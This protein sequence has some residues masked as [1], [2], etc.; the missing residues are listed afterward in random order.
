MNALI[1]K[2]FTSYLIMPFLAVV[3]TF[4]A[5]LISKKNKLFSNKKT[6]FYVL[7]AGLLLS[8][9]GLLGFLDYE[10]M[11]YYYIGLFILYLLA[12]WGNISWIRKMVPNVANEG[13]PYIMEFLVHFAIM[14]IGAAL[15]SVIF[16]LCNELQY[17]LWACTCV[18]GFV[19]PT[20]F[21]H[22]YQQYMDIPLE[23]HKTWSYSYN[24]DLSGFEYMDYNKLMLIELEFFKEVYDATSTK[25]KVKAPDNLAFGT[26]FQKFILDYNVKFPST[27]IE[28]KDKTKK[29]D[30]KWIFYVKRSFFLPRKYIDYEL[31]IPQNQ[32]KEK[33]T[34]IAKR[35]FQNEDENRNENEKGNESVSESGSGNGNGNENK[36][37]NESNNKPNA[38]KD[39]M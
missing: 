37:E 16:N 18:L 39:I 25:V 22:T 15:F 24:E 21:Y 6:I 23:V 14:F 38:I 30:Y 2:L 7:L 31:T 12:G 36:N 20:L 17:G 3:F 33:H 28:T 9:P 34:V 32:I 10:F 29:T 1:V 4:A 5:Y 11:P 27:P 8:I 19:F 26:W 35:V 13:T